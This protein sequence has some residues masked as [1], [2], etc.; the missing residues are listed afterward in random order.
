[1]FEMAYSSKTYHLL[2]QHETQETAT[3]HWRIELNLDYLHLL[4]LAQKV[5]MIESPDNQK[6][7]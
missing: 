1:M 5:Q 4:G 7:E 2:Q 6:H 3:L